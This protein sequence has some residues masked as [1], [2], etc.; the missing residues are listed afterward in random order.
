MAVERVAV[1]TKA[2][3]SVEIDM[4]EVERMAVERLEV[5]YISHDMP[6]NS[7]T[8]GDLNRDTIRAKN[9]K[10]LHNFEYRYCRDV[11]STCCLLF[12]EPN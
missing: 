6:H 7:S 5:E 10:Q 12:F 1:K 3:E 4:V 9:D 8:L 2:A 11:S